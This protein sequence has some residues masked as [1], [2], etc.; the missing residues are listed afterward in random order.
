[1]FDDQRDIKKRMNYEYNIKFVVMFG[2]CLQ[3][4]EQIL[5]LSIKFLH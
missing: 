2:F 3:N 1:M 4:S 5:V